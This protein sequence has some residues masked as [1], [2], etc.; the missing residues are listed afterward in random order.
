MSFSQTQL[1]N[2]M[3]A[4]GVFVLLLSQFGVVVE[5]ESAAYIISALWSLGWT[6]YNYYQRY[7]KGDL[8]LG[9]VRKGRY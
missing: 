6:A 5:K 4:A 7:R 8:T 9:G 3:T 1:A 2:I